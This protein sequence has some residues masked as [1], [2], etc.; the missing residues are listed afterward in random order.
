MYGL[1][2]LLAMLDLDIIVNHAALDG[3]GAI[4]GNQGDDVL[5]A[6]RLEL[7]EEIPHSLGFKLEDGDRF[8]LAEQLV[9]ARIVQWDVID[10]E[11]LAAGFQDLPG[12][13]GDDGKGP[14]TEKIH[15]QHADV[16]EVL[17]GPLAQDV[18]TVLTER[19]HV[20]ERGVSDDDT[21]R[22]GGLV[23]VEAL[24]PL[25]YLEEL[26]D[27]GIFS[28]HGRQLLVRR[29]ALIQLDPRPSG[30]LLGDGID[31]GQRYVEGPSDIP[32][33]GPGRHGA[34][35]GDLADSILSIFLADVV[36]NLLPP[37]HAEVDI[38]IRHGDTVDIQESLEQQVV[39]QGV[40]VGDAQ[41]IGDDASRGG[42]SAGPDGDALLFGVADKVPGDEEVA[43]KSHLLDDP[44]L[45]LEPVQGLLVLVKIIVAFTA[46][47][48]AEPKEIGLR[49][50]FFFILVDGEWREVG[51]AEVQ[52]EIAHLRDHDGVFDRL[53]EVLEDAVHLLLVAEEEFAR[54]HAQPVV[55]FHRL[56]GVD[57][58]VDLLRPG[59]LFLQVVDIIGG[60]HRDSVFL[61]QGRNLFKNVPLFF[62]SVV[63]DLE[64]ERP[65]LK[66]AVVVF[67]F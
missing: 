33:D 13:A 16:L 41:G 42:A 17:H 53:G 59:V 56:A 3:A 12:A 67:D 50:I 27:A 66:D 6:V 22:M 24:E 1:P 54:V 4:Q 23:A 35:G 5:E 48:P 40:D 15:L 8:P 29:K 9:G 57:A 30:D 65:W 55:I 36:D 31:L 21:R 14:E 44:D 28:P 58:E 43:D 63:L 64:E 51:L 32:D 52:L 39:A 47:I 11:C 60:D 18:V 26:G 25:G 61:R 46:P 38:D 19:D 45:V 37:I 2:L 7:L 49:V 20:D 62:Q 34:E 10:F